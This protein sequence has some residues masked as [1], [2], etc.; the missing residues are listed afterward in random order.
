MKGRTRQRKS[1]LS[2][3]TKTP[4]STVR[5][6]P[7]PSRGPTS[8]VRRRRK[9]RR[10]ARSPLP[11]PPPPPR[12]LLLPSRPLC[13]APRRVAGLPPSSASSFSRSSS[14]AWSRFP[15]PSCSS[16]SRRPPSASPTRPS[17]S[18][19]ITPRACASKYSPTSWQLPPVGR[20]PQ[21]AR[22]CLSALKA[23]ARGRRSYWFMAP[24]ARPLPSVCCLTRSL[25]GAC[26]P[27]R[28]TFRG[29]A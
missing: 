18:Y 27:L 10:S 15:P 29:T 21:E 23:L 14:Y 20:P 6:S 3:G 17:P 7:C 5:R 4:S 28:L 8:S 24:R 16:T 1:Q 2:R 11:P 12:P 9:R 22:A 19:S 13:R 25:R 26:T